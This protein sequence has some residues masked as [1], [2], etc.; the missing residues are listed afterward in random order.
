M[1]DVQWTGWGRRRR[2]APWLRLCQA[3]TIG[4]CA[5]LLHAE[6][7]RRGFP[8]KQQ[9]L[10]HGDHPPRGDRHQAGQVEEQPPR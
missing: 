8:D 10:V 5:R 6:G 3:A 1:A 9:C 7:K 4:E 2:G